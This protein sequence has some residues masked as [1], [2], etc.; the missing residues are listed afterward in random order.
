MKL[1]TATSFSRGK[2][3]NTASRAT[4]IIMAPPMPWITRES[5]SM[6]RLPD[7]A[8]ERDPNTKRATA[9]RKTLR[10][11]KRSANQPLAGINRAT[12]RV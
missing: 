1:S 6:R 8:Q 10:V 11:P 3:R 5:T 9:N 7:R 4:G 2:A 12:V